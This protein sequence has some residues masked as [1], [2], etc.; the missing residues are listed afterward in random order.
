MVSIITVCFNVEDTIEKTMRSVLDQTYKDLEYII[1]DGSSHD[2]TIDIVN[3]VIKS[4]PNRTI[5]YISEP[6]NGL[7]DA[8]NKGILLSNGEWIGIMNSGD[9]YPSEKSLEDFFS[10]PKDFV[11]KDVVYGNAIE[12]SNGIN[13]RWRGDPNHQKLELHPTYRHGASFVRASVHKQNLFRIEKKEF[14]FALDYDNI[15]RMYKAGKTF[16]FIDKDILIYK[17]EGISNQRWKGIFLIFYITSQYG[18]LLKPT[19]WL[20]RSLAVQPLKNLLNR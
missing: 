14:S 2:R 3:N 9:Y 5:H 17:K 13:R 18:N 6:D 11:G 19:L 7:Y 1:I 8:M 12:V 16:H 15:F 4:Y 10:N 20:L